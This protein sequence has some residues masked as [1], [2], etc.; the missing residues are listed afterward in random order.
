MAESRS[1]AAY[2]IES[3]AADKA[4]ALILEYFSHRGEAHMEE[5]RTPN[6]KA[7]GSNPVTPAISEEDVIREVGLAIEG[8]TKFK[9]FLHCPLED[10]RC[11]PKISY[12]ISSGAKVYIRICLFHAAAYQI[13]SINW[14]RYE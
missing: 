7:A 2:V 1:D 5:C 13:S 3:S 9:F 4:L 12:F 11:H 10:G 8:F 6:P 14:C